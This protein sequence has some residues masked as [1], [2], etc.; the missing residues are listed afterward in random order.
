MLRFAD[1]TEDEDLLEQA[2]LSAD[3]LLR[4]SPAAAR[5]HLQRWMANKHDFLQV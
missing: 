5:A 2:R 1:L 4:E 3:E